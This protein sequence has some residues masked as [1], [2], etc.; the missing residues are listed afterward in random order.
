MNLE[1][2]KLTDS[3]KNI[4]WTYIF[5]RFMVQFNGTQNLGGNYEKNEFR[6][7]QYK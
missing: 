3:I 2:Y 6:K 1:K 4:I 7:R 5:F